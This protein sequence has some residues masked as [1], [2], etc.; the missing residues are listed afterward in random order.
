MKER[1]LILLSLLLVLSLSL[2]ACSPAAPAPADVAE[3]EVVEEADPAEEPAAEEPMVAG[4]AEFDAAYGQMLSSMTAYNTVKMDALAE[5]L[6][7]TPPFLIDVRTDDELSENGHIPGAI[8]IPLNELGQHLDLL[9]GYDTPI[10][11]Y[12]AG[13]WRATIAMTQLAAAGWTDVRALKARFADWVDAGYAVDPGFPPEADPLNA[14]DP[15]A[16]FV[17]AFGTML[18][19]RE[20][21]GGISADDLNL[22]LGEDPDRILIDVR[23]A[24]ELETNGVID[25]PNVVEIPVEEFVAQR[26]AWP[27]DLD[28]PITI[29]CGSGHR[30]TIAASIMWTYGYTNVTSLQGGFGGWKDAGYA[31][32]GGAADPDQLF[33]SMLS[34]M[35]AYNTVKADTLTVELLE[36]PPPFLLDV[37][38]AGELEESGHIPGAIHIPLNELGDHL[39]LLPSFDTPIVAYCGSGWRATIA[40]TYLSAAGW[41]D[42]R[43]LKTTFA[44]WVAGGYAVEPGLAAEPI[45]LNVADPDATFWSQVGDTLAA[46]E[47][48]GVI[49]ADD[50]NLAIVEN[51][52]LVLIDVRRA[53]ELQEKG[54][55]EG[56]IHIPIETFI[57]GM[58]NW[59][60][61]KDSKI[62]VYCGSGHRSTMGMAILWAYG[63]DNVQ[64]LKGGFGGW[65]EAGYPIVE[66]VMQ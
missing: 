27:S 31:T 14:A 6:L 11:T 21:W 43:A 29:Y 60:A 54:V 51:P 22:A 53:E 7:D 56:A 50:L 59:P 32:V 36:E 3:P 38:T 52:E 20:G 19:N 65:V 1:I 44:D 35:E 41:E 16:A 12:C 13:G 30:S 40:M 37:R 64:S 8:H 48:W 26:D 39:D 28:A 17:E 33:A 63:Y 10:V 46:R 55:I 42:V 24:E 45:V 66:Y 15:D 2:G 34:E 49:T 58:A 18:S 62:V 9:P 25:A 23:R 61:D 4:P 57:D 5:E 47:G